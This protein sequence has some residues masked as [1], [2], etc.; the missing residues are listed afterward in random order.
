MPAWF[1]AVPGPKAVVDL[2][3]V[4]QSAL[5]G[6]WPLPCAFGVTPVNTIPVGL[7]AWHVVQPLVIPLW[8]ITPEFGPRLPF[9][10]HVVHARLVGRW[11]AGLPPVTPIPNDTVELWHVEQSADVVW[12]PAPCAFGVTPANT[13][14][15]APTAWQAMQPLVIP[16]WFIAVPAKLVKLPAAWQ[17]S[18]VAVVG[19]WFAGLVLRFDTP[20]KLFP[21]S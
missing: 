3:H 4:M 11:F 10:W 15:A 16:L 19:R 20:V 5:V 2:W 1:I 9:A 14:P 6:M 17:L 21:V 8:F 18:Q 12:C 7:A 13:F